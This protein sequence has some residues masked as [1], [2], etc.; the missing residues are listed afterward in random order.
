M[1]LKKRTKYNADL[2]LR[3]FS[4]TLEKAWKLFLFALV[5]SSLGL[6]VFLLYWYLSFNRAVTEVS[7]N[8]IAAFN[9]TISV[10]SQVEEAGESPL[11]SGYRVQYPKLRLIG[12]EDTALKNKVDFE[13]VKGQR[14]KHGLNYSDVRFKK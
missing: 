6:G 13:K 7:E 3:E 4:F 9:S 1:I 12:S 11:I 14:R 8:A 2:L 10:Y 5:W